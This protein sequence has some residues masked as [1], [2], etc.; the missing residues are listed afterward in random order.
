MEDGRSVASTS[1]IME[2]GRSVAS[3]SLTMEARIGKLYD[4]RIARQSSLYPNIPMA[5]TH[6][7]RL[8]DPSTSRGFINYQRGNMCQMELQ[9]QTLG[10]QYAQHDQYNVSTSTSYGSHLTEKVPLALQDLSRRQV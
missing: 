8:V 2:A 9:T 6:L 1:S 10:S 5:A 4:R 3:T 7:L